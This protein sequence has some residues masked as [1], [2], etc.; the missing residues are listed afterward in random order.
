MKKIKRSRELKIRAHGGE[1]N[2]INHNMIPLDSLVYK[3]K[4][5]KIGLAI[6]RSIVFLNWGFL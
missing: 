3:S 2:K 5:I 4:A 6:C 1:F